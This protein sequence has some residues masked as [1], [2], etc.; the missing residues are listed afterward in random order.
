MGTLSYE[1]FPVP[2]DYAPV[3]GDG[4]SQLRFEAWCAGVDAVLDQPVPDPFKEPEITVN[5][6]AKAIRPQVQYRYFEIQFVD[7]ETLALYRVVDGAG[8]NAPV[9]RLE[10]T[11][12]HANH[13]G[14]QPVPVKEGGNPSTY[15]ELVLNPMY[16][17]I[18]DETAQ[19]IEARILGKD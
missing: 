19:A 13:E 1:G 18:D 17:R 3:C 16:E 5:V 9:E 7:G 8:E 6:T 11:R 10:G 12:Y 14:W 4:V 2:E 15:K